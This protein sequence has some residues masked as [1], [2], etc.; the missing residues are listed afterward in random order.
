MKADFLKIINR[1]FFIAIITSST[2]VTGC[3]FSV[4]W[5]Y[6][7]N[8]DRLDILYDALSVTSAIG[9]IFGFTLLSLF[10]FSIVIFISSFLLYL[11]YL[12]N[13]QSLKHYEGLPSRLAN[14]S[15]VNSIMI[16]I[17]FISGISLYYFR[18]WNGFAVTITAIGLLLLTTW[19]MSRWQIFTP[20]YVEIDNALE[21][22]YLATWPIKFGLPALLLIPAC[23]QVLPLLFV[24]SQLD[25]NSETSMLAQL[26]IFTGLSVV[27]AVVGI[28][29][30]M[31]LVSEQK[32]IIQMITT[33][34]IVIPALVFLMTIFF[35][36]TPNL[37]INMTLN[38][39]GISDW[40]THQYYIETQTHPHAMFDGAT[41]NT[42]YYK[43]IPSRFF[44]TGVN[45][46]S[47]GNIQLICP[48]QINA[49]RAASLK[50]TA[51][52]FEAYDL[53]SK[54]LKRTAM[55]CIPFKKEQIYQ[56]D[57]PISEPVFY[58]KVKSTGS[59]SIL[60]LL[61]EIKPPHAS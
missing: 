5:F 13:E 22:K 43:D 3:T 16:C 21:K 4:I 37:L 9:I 11:I 26:T 59:N 24:T 38:L 17:V 25:F 18:N 36:P 52:D 41:W 23:V 50:T 47:L 60:D 42:R 6:L 28:F 40:R 58:Q 10:G 34:V 1:K 54:A 49:A 45:I 2:F 56:W 57:S 55:K 33:I 7:A 53:R 20:A 39:S 44:I 29:P 30:G 19:S 61:K 35:R 51:D 27:L 48:S 32:N 8:I 31:I 15:L 46:F 12:S 14:V